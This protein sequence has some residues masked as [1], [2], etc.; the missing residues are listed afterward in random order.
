MNFNFWEYYNMSTRLGMADGRC[1]TVST[2]STLF[3][4][5]VMEK[6]KIPL[7]DNYRYRQ[8]LQNKGPDAID[9]VVY[10]AQPFG[11]N[12]RGSP[13]CTECNTALLKVPGTF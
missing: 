13:L 4:D 3:N 10:A 7:V 2:A 5:Y 6:N 1:F 8:L 9:R 11:N 12:M